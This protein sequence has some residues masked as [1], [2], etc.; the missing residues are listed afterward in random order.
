LVLLGLRHD[1]RYKAFVQRLK[2][3]DGELR[4][5]GGGG[6]R[7]LP[8]D[9]PR[10]TLRSWIAW[11]VQKLGEMHVIAHLLTVVSLVGVC[12]P[13]VALRLAAATFAVLAV[14]AV[15]LAGYFILR[16]TMRGEAEAEFAAWHRVPHDAFLEFRDGR[17]VV[18]AATSTSRDR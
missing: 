6:G 1:A 16:S 12:L 15:A 2:L 3:V 17:W 13:G 5:I 4:T 14:P 11:S 18:E 10:P 9:W 7:P 8:A